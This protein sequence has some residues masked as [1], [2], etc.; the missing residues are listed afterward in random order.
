MNVGKILDNCITKVRFLK[1]DLVKIDKELGE[2]L[3]RS[4][5][6]ENDLN[7]VKKSL[8][9]DKCQNLRGGKNG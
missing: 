6:L 7:A 9:G 8:E 1:K 2:A 4:N 5:F 3:T